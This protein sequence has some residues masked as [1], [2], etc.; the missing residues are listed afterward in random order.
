[1]RIPA[2]TRSRCR[3]RRRAT[4]STVRVS[5]NGVGIPEPERKKVFQRFYR[6]KKEGASAGYGLGL[7]L[8]AAI[9]KLH[10]IGIALMDNAPGLRVDLRF[11]WPRGGRAVRLR[12]AIVA[13]SLAHRGT[14]C[15]GS[16]QHRARCWV[17][18]PAAGRAAMASS[19]R[20]GASSTPPTW[21]C[22]TMT[23]RRAGQ[24]A[25]HRRPVPGRG[26]PLHRLDRPRQWARSRR[27]HR[28]RRRGRR[29]QPDRRILD[30]FQRRL[31]RGPDGLVRR[32]P[33]AAM[34]VS[35]GRDRELFRLLPQ[36]V[37]RQHRH[38]QQRLHRRG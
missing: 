32:C 14:G 25:Q 31:R 17:L 30:L 10:R 6:L 38:Q 27:P 5:D 4:A 2:A 1:M 7:S 34:R 24:R 35:A 3:P 9:A 37:G 21:P 19:C 12:C 15:A 13:G 29:R 36:P 23:G 28:A 26:D 22:S 8:V 18:S 16:W 11:P 33:G 20:S